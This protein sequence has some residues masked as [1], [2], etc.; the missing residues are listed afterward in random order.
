MR[1][2][3]APTEA[4]FM[5]GDVVV[6]AWKGTDADGNG[7]IALV[8]LV[9]VAGRPEDLPGLVSVPPPQ[10]EDAVRWAQQVFQRYGTKGR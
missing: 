8:S 2:T 9:Q 1:L 7:V 6:R 3:I 10:P 5:Q 4:F